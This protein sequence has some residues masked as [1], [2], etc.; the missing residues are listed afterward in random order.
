ML[1]ADMIDSLLGNP[2]ERP[3]YESLLADD[4][5]SRLA[6]RPKEKPLAP[7]PKE[8]PV[9]T[10]F[11]YF[12]KNVAGEELGESDRGKYYDEETDSYRVYQ[13]KGEDRPTVG[14][15]VYLN[16][17]ALKRL[18]LSEVPSVGQL[19]PANVIDQLAQNR[20][21]A[22][23]KRASRELTGTKGEKSIGP[24][25]E[26]IYQMGSQVVTPGKNNKKYFGETLKSLKLGNLEEAKKH[27][28]NST[29]YK[30]TTNRANR[31]IGRFGRS[32]L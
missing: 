16:D 24:L 14:K 25:A 8:K 10:A 29:W 30:Q 3:K 21:M 9:P 32:K 26:M 31:V 18:N 17:A 20:W 27:A 22:A 7:R 1:L 4:R 2:V 15:G 5:D 11:K 13:L 12:D 28:K 19:I 6:S 23:V